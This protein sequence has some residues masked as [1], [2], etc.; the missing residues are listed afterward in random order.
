MAID[1][2]YVLS[3]VEGGDDLVDDLERAYFYYRQA[4]RLRGIPYQR[5]RKFELGLKAAKYL[6]K[7]QNEE[8]IFV[9]D[10]HG[11][12]LDPLYPMPS[13]DP[14]VYRL[15]AL[16]ESGPRSKS[17]LLPYS[18]FEWLTGVVLPRIFEQLLPSMKANVGRHGGRDAERRPPE[19]R[20]IRFA[21]Q[22]LIEFG[23]CKSNGQPYSDEALAKA[24]TN[25]RTGRR[26]RKG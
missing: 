18:A 23:I 1:P 13:L 26:R 22:F 20:Y 25:A 11:R 21:R 7:L 4:L 10:D 3:N 16:S 17:K 19:G 12:R 9:P 8:H 2:E 24:L 5:R 6:K 14:W 15:H